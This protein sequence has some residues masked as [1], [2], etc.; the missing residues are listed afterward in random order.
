MRHDCGL[1]TW[2]KAC[3]FCSNSF[4]GFPFLLDGLCLCVCVCVCFFN[5]VIARFEG[6]F[7]DYLDSDYLEW[8]CDAHL[9]WPLSK[10]D[11]FIV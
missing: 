2:C 5:I 6:C 1:A 11:R 8:G 10:G 9:G 7:S 4:A 3:G